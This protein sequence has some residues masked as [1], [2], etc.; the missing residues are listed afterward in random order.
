MKTKT[1][2][3]GFFAFFFLHLKWTY[4]H[5]F[6]CPIYFIY[7]LFRLKLVV[8]IKLNLFKAFYLILIEYTTFF[9]YKIKD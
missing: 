5:L 7:K 9:L 3:D 4:L 8:K 6:S 2:F 1:Y